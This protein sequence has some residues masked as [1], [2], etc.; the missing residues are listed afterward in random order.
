MIIYGAETG[1]TRVVKASCGVRCSPPLSGNFITANDNAQF[2]AA[3]DN[4]VV[5]GDTAIAA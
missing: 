4:F 3:N 5:E 2:V 1:S